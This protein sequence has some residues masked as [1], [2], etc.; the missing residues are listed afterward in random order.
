MVKIYHGTPITARELAAQEEAERIDR[1]NKDFARWDSYQ[2]GFPMNA[3]III[4]DGD[5]IGVHKAGAPN[6]KLIIGL[7]ALLLVLGI[8][9]SRRV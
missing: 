4:Q 5:K 6:T 9:V 2:V 8:I 3:D 7:V 1:W